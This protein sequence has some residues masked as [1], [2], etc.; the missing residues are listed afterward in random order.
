MGTKECHALFSLPGWWDKVK[1]IMSKIK[2]M[3]CMRISP[4]CMQEETT[5]PYCTRFVQFHY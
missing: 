3:R 4:R 2:N 5:A 1:A